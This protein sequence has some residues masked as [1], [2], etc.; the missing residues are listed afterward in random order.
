MCFVATHQR[1]LHTPFDIAITECH[2]TALRVLCNVHPAGT[3]AQ[4]ALGCTLFHLAAF[5][6]QPSAIDVMAAVNPEGVRSANRNGD[7]S[8]HYAC[9]KHL[10]CTQVLLHWWPQGVL[11]RN[12]F[13]RTALHRATDA[14][15]VDIVRLM[16]RMCPQGVAVVELDSRRTPLHLA[17]GNGGPLPLLEALIETGPE[18][19]LLRD[20]QGRLPLH[21]AALHGHME[22]MSVIATGCARTWEV[23]DDDGHTPRDLAAA[24]DVSNGRQRRRR[25]ID[26]TPSIKTPKCITC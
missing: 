24:A 18:V 21:C 10:D 17:A 3:R 22:A 1:N 7:V 2:V 23:R 12:R 14:A 25:R 8:L 20:A 6:N 15:Q 16:L 19:R 26:L 13:H 9:M 11:F 5:L 4:D